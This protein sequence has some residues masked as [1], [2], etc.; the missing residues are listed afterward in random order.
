DWALLFQWRNDQLTRKMSLSSERVPLLDHLAW[1]GRRTGPGGPGGLWIAHL[2]FEPIGTMR[3]D[4]DELS[5][6]V[7]PAWRGRG[8]GS[9]MVKDF[10]SLNPRPYTAKI[11]AD[12]FLSIRIAEAAGIA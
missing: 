3:L 8:L 10:V 4:G 11:K 7:G 2:H 9:Q 1:L 12:N 6:T 5:W